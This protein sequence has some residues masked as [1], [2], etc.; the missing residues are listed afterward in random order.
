MR[1]GG[2]RVKT[3]HR[4]FVVNRLAQTTRDTLRMDVKANGKCLV[5]KDTS[6]TKI[7]FPQEFLTLLA[8]NGKFE[9]VG[10][11]ER[12]KVKKLSEPKGL[13]IVILRRK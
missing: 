11:F 5:L 3:T 12:D 8:L 6:E 1:S 9:F 13:N 2:V 10:W 4:S 7:I